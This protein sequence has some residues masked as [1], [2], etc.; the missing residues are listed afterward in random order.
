MR[1]SAS[2]ACSARYSWTNPMIPLSATMIR[3]MAV[4]LRSPMA[5]VIAAAPSR[6][7]IIALVN[8]SAS[9]RQAGLAACSSSSFGPR[10]IRRRRAS[11]GSRPRSASEPSA[12]DDLRSVDRPWVPDA[13]DRGDVLDLDA[14]GSAD[15]WGHGHAAGFRFVAPGV[16][17]VTSAGT[18]PSVNAA[19]CSAK[20]PI[21][22]IGGIGHPESGG[23][24]LGRR[25]RT[26]VA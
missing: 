5:A 13:V 16:I 4:S 18:I 7:R 22:P 6:T 14:R 1:L 23:P 3:M 10:V 8:C 20:V 12:A 24:A 9:R 19:T 2:I 15:A 26:T 21:G 17:G 25:C 11:S